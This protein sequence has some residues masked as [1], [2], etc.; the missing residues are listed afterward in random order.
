MNVIKYVGYAWLIEHFG[1]S[2][3]RPVAV[4]SEAGKSRT[5]TTLNHQVSQT[6]PANMVPD[7]DLASQLTFAFKY[8]GV[9]LELLARLF[10]RIGP[11]PIETW[12]R[13]EPRGIY[14][15]RAGFLYEWLSGNV[16]DVPMLTGGAYTDALDADQYHVASEVVPNQKWRVRDNLPGTPAY[17]PMVR[18]TTRTVRAMSFDCRGQFDNLEKE[19]GAQLLKRSAVWLTL[20]ESKASFAIENEQD[21]DDRIKRFAYAMEAYTGHFQNPFSAESLKTLQQ[22]ILGDYATRF[23]MRQS[24]VFVGH[25]VS[26][27]GVV[28]YIAPRWDQTEA[29][30][31]GLAKAME[32]TARGPSVLRAAIASFGFVYIHPMSDGNGRVSRF[33][34]NDVLRRD[35]AV[36]P[37]FILPVSATISEHIQRTA[38]YDKTL[39]T[40]SR[41]FMERYRD[42]YRMGAETEYPDG[43]QAT[44]EFDAYDDALYAWR[45]PDFTAH[46][47]FMVDVIDATINQEMRTEA[48]LL[49]SQDEAR[50]AV[51]NIVEG[52]NA[53]LDRIIRSVRQN[54]YQVSGKLRKDFPVLE[55]SPERAARLVA[56]IRSV[57]EPEAMTEDEQ[58][59]EEDEGE[60]GP[61]AL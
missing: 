41:P 11:D 55:R 4:R 25:N 16:L 37:P 9:E 48:L 54:G 14:A 46:S 35:G 47:E 40:I 21:Q 2:L 3:A 39:D 7:D 30:L 50:L 60:G 23:G 49:K 27:Q 1:L 12:V 28:D 61:P 24:P 22:S 31:A 29:L 17:C 34:I 52:P 58:Y 44:L 5:T 8:E 36:P 15:R 10:D 33:L 59:P 19:V 57:F 38:D 45:F 51:K 20:K 26:H 13:S 56:A 18:K 42:D 43:V 53:D 32:R 6:F